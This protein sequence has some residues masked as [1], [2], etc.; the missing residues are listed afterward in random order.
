[1]EGQADVLSLHQTF[2]KDM[3]NGRWVYSPYI[4]LSAKEDGKAGSCTPPKSGIYMVRQACVL[5]LIQAVRWK[6]GGSAPCFRLSKKLTTS[7]LPQTSMEGQVG[8][9]SLH[10]SFHK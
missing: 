1:M 4:R 8:V 6:G 5:S 9:L 3:W 7:V 10:H 2:H